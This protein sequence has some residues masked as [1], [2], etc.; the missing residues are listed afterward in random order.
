MKAEDLEDVEMREHYDFSQ[1]VPSPYAA[2]AGEVHL[3]T[4]DPDVQAVF[5]DSEAVNEA[6]R[7]LMKAAKSVPI[8]AKAS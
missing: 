2:L 4:L 7:V 8:F 3:V 5:K 1:S 6:L